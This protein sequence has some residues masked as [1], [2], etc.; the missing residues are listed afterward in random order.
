MNLKMIIRLL[1]LLMLILCTFMGLSILIAVAYDEPFINIYSFLVPIVLNVCFFL[2]VFFSAQKRELAYLSPKSGFLFVTFAWIMASAI[3]ALPYYISGV[4]PSYT[5]AFFETMAGFTT[6][7]ASVIRD[8][9]LVPKSILFWRSLTHWLGGMGI[10]V[11][12]VA[13]FPLLG[14]GGLSLMEAEAPGPSVTKISP[15][16]TRTAKILWVIYIGFTMVLAILLLFGGMDVYDA[17]THSFV[18]ISTGGCSVKN[19]NIRYYHS[20]FIEIVLIVFMLLSGINFP[21]HYKILTGKFKEAWKDSELKAYF[22]IFVIFTFLITADLLYLGVY[23]DMGT[24]LRYAGFQVSSI[25]TTTGF[26]VDDYMKWGSFSQILLFLLL[27]VGG[28]AG[29]TGGGIKVIRF[30][31]IFKMAVT[32]MKYLV[33]P[34]GVF[35]IFVNNQYLKKNIVYDCA[36]FVFLYLLIFILTSLVVA[37]GGYD[38]LTTMSTS[39]ACLSNNGIGLG[40]VGPNYNFSLFP[41][42]IAW[43]LSFAMLVGRLEVYTVLILLTPT[44]WKR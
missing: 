5:N 43:T 4:L 11:L 7:G 6:T 2:S 18:T 23:Q 9:D 31:T 22:A 1:S 27:F 15:R 38:F 24:T 10:V 29:S 21:L 17:V 19:A 39:I 13:I 32:E 12:T 40:S 33:R 14:Y 42:Y 35:G 44:F 25:L 37:T 16:A 30:I 34:R 36:A 3:G 28:C 26:V 8:V 20:A 41:D